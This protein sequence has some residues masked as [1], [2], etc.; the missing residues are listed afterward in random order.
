M[1]TKFQHLFDEKK[2]VKILVVGD[3]ILDEY[4]WGSVSRISPE[5]PVPILESKSENLALGGAANVANNLV[6]LGCDVYLVGG[7]G[8]DE[9]GDKLLELI[10]NRNIHTDG[11]FRF[12]HRPTT[13]KIRV[14]AHNQQVLRIDK[15]DNRPILPETEKKIINYINETVPQMDGVICSDYNKGILTEKVTHTIMHRAKNVKKHVVVDPKG[16]DFSKYKGCTVI[17]PNQLE[18]ERVAPIK[19]ATQEDLDRAAEYLISLA[20]AES[21]LVT[22]GKEGMILYRKKKKPV[23]IP[24]VAREVFDVTGAGDTVISV[25]GMSLFSGFTFEE[26]ARLSNMAAGIVVGKIGTAV[27]TLNELNQ[28]LQEDMLRT[29]PTIL[30]VEEAKKIVS[31]AKNIGKK[32]VF[33]NGC[34]DLIHGGHIEFLQKSRRMGDILILGLNSD[35][36]VRAIK[37][38]NRP[39]KNQQERANILSALQDVDYIVIFNEQTP[40]NLIREL[41]PDILVKGDDYKID[42]VVGREIV[43]SYGGKVALV[44][45]VKGLSTTNTLDQILQHHKS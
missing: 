42:Q 29:S 19:I 13:S 34:Y 32:V 3:L 40:E 5:A 1:K 12:V 37:G 22:R 10:G 15:E 2:R 17:T 28:F 35:D 25:F 9:K 30:E 16:T 38:P 27:V 7:V 33:T 36:S 24:T 45:I 26:A 39:I 21:I 6:A 43:E 20:K 14:I 8:K 18:V 31:L 41:R 4:I 11:I 44:P 23:D